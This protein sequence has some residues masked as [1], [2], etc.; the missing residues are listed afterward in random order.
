[1]R[2]NESLQKFIRKRGSKKPKVHPQPKRA[3]LVFSASTTPAYA[4]SDDLTSIRALLLAGVDPSGHSNVCAA[5]APP[6]PGHHN[7]SAHHTHHTHHAST[8][9]GAGSSVPSSLTD[10]ACIAASPPQVNHVLESIAVSSM[11]ASSFSHGRIDCHSA[12][13]HAP[14]DPDPAH[15][16]MSPEPSYHKAECAG[17][18]VSLVEVVDA[19][20]DLPRVGSALSVS[21]LGSVPEFIDDGPVNMMAAGEAPPAMAKDTEASIARTG[22]AS[23]L[24]SL[25]NLSVSSQ[26]SD[27]PM[28]S[29]DRL[30]DASFDQQ[31]LDDLA[32]I[33]FGG[34]W[35]GHLATDL[36]L[37]LDSA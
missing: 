10:D 27:V 12:V 5:P 16:H 1:M 28:L 13:A 22:S 37:I 19:Q 4:R 33:D 2:D 11:A 30:D 15:M 31:D 29:G 32:P 14:P 20:C 35:A 18:A 7:Q 21:S 8:P 17:S 25:G 3:K 26:L 24:T 6:L 23:S 34:E 9:V 36:S